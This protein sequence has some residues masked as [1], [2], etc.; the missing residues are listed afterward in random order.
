MHEEKTKRTAVNSSRMDE[1]DFAVNVFMTQKNESLTHS[2][3]FKRSRSKVIFRVTRKPCSCRGRSF[4]NPTPDGR[5]T[6]KTVEQT[7]ISHPDGRF[8]FG[9]PECAIYYH[10]HSSITS[11][12]QCYGK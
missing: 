3:F 7:D 12:I 2:F 11:K 1:N 10:T 8:H 4:I 9:L 6:D 5:M